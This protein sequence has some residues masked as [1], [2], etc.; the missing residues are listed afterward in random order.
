MEADRNSPHKNHNANSPSK[1]TPDPREESTT[2][3][4]PKTPKKRMSPQIVIPDLTYPQ[5]STRIYLTYKSSTSA[6]ILSMQAAPKH[7]MVTLAEKRRLNLFEV[8]IK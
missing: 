1:P 7:N 5:H 6:T 8:A 3:P 4:I 2:K